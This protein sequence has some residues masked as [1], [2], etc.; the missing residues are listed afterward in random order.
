M[1]TVTGPSPLGVTKIGAPRISLLRIIVPLSDKVPPEADRLTDLVQQGDLRKRPKHSAHRQRK[2]AVRLRACVG[3]QLLV[4][5][6]YAHLQLPFL[7]P[8]RQ[9]DNGDVRQRVASG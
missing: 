5:S 1:P 2:T 9:I 7:Q 3:F 8:L 4:E 6:Q